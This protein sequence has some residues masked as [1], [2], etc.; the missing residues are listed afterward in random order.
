[1]MG[2][3][4]VEAIIIPLFAIFCV[5]CAPLL[6]VLPL[7]W[8]NKKPQRNEGINN[9][10]ETQLIQDLNRLAHR[11]EERIETLETLMV[12]KTDEPRPRTAADEQRGSRP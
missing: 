5:F 8:M 3:G 12:D 7:F 2:L 9:A 11:L 1:M 6:F 10:A 4:L